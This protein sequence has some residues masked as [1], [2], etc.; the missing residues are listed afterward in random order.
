[1]RTHTKTF[2]IRFTETEYERL[3]KYAEKAG[4]PKTT[5]I[6]HMI[7]GCH[8]KEQPSMDY[9]KF[10]EELRRVGNNL[11][12]IAHLAHRFGSLHAA[13]LN[14]TLEEYN[15]LYLAIT[16]RMIPPDDLYVPT[17]LEQGKEVAESDSQIYK[18]Q[19][20]NVDYESGI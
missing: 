2:H 6:R 16:N 11:N 1:M 14:T 12:Q 3:C 17:T 4:L 19:R 7:N 18:N 15:R 5:Y 9:Y 13:K 8:P 10:M 20:S